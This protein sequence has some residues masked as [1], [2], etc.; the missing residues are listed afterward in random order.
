V[1]L[2]AAM[3]GAA[4]RLAMPAQIAILVRIPTPTL[5]HPAKEPIILKRDDL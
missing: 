1:T 2:S 4:S 5:P 3:A